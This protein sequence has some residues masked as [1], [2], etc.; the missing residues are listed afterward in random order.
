MKRLVEEIGWPVV[1]EFGIREEQC[2][3][4]TKTAIVPSWGLR[5][6]RKEMAGRVM[7]SGVVAPAWQ[8][9]G[10]HAVCCD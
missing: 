10:V 1:D 6:W 5:A 3:C 2:S 7:G 8:Y 4:K 9:L